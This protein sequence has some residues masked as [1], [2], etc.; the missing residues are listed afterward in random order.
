VPRG[1]A[2]DGKGE[3]AADRNTYRIFV[4]IAIPTAGITLRRSAV[5]QARKLRKR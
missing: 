4:P 5:S 2:L 3:V 1:G